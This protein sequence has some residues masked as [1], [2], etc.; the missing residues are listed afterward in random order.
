MRNLA[1]SVLLAPILAACTA[2][3]TTSLDRFGES[4]R[5]VALSGAGAGAANACFTCHGLQGK[6]NG[7]GA[8]R[9]AALDA[10]YL[11]RQLE[12]YAEGDRYHSQMAWIARKLNPRERADVALFYA[13]MPFVPAQQRVDQA[14]SD[15]YHRG[16]PRRGLPACAGC[17]GAE[18]AGMGPANP[19]FA[20]QPASYLAEQLEQWRK[21]RRRTDPGGVMLRIS[22]LLSPDEVRS[23]SAYAARLPGRLPNP[24]SPAA[25]P[26][27]HRADPR[28][29]ASGPP[30]HV[31]ESARAAE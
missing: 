5:L 21:G 24:G 29:D 11:Q 12:A 26:A 3:E 14:S 20:G 10:G 8:P 28:S 31:P 7:S 22:Q 25:F 18:G 2:A 23:V 19:P 13:G 27:A 30:L 16:D 9:L 6:G 17:H 15:L 1:A 4:G